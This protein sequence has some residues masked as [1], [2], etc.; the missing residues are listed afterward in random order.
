MALNF[1]LISFKIL[2]EVIKYVNPL[3]LLKKYLEKFK[4]FEIFLWKKRLSF[5]FNYN[6]FLLLLFSGT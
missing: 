3:N 2:K 6:Y 5:F 1:R 4:E